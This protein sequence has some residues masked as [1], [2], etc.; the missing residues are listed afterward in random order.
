MVADVDPCPTYCWSGTCRIGGA[1][2]GDCTSTTPAAAQAAFGAFNATCP[3]G[4][5]SINI[6]QV[7]SYYANVTCDNGNTFTP[8]PASSSAATH[9]LGKGGLLACSLSGASDSLELDGR[10]LTRSELRSVL[11]GAS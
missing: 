11:S 4:T 3:A 1:T 5:P 2:E 6:F 7:V 9:N 8:G 10:T